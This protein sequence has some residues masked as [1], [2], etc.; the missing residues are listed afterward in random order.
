MPRTRRE[1]GMTLRFGLM[2]LAVGAFC[3][4]DADATQYTYSTTLDP[5]TAVV[6]PIFAGLQTVSLNISGA[7]TFTL[8]AGDTLSGTLTLTQPLIVEGPISNPFP[9]VD[10][11]LGCSDCKNVSGTE[12]MTLFGVS[13][14]IDASNPSGGPFSNFPIN[15]VFDFGVTNSFMSFSS[16]DYS[17]TISSFPDGG[18]SVS[19]TPS[20]LVMDDPIGSPITAAPEPASIAAFGVGMVGLATLWRR[21]HRCLRDDGCL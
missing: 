9:L 14:E 8:G 6:A 12:Q 10:L 13:G 4:W 1:T 11:E 3:S 2:V 7:P 5:S 16:L 17:I 15:D 20:A 18:T 21:R 19:F